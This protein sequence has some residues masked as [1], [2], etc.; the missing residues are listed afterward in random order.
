MDGTAQN[1]IDSA[2]PVAVLPAERI[3]GWFGRILPLSFFESLKEDLEL[4]E[5]SCIF[6]LRV[7][8]WMMIMQRLSPR[9]TLATA[10]SEL[11]HGNG[12]ELL[13]P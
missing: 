9:G 10:V 12:R 5:N 13:Q 6:T 7:T 4:V 2:V 8:T 11:L 3:R 1:K